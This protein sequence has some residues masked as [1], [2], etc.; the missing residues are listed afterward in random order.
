MR[1]L[2]EIH[3]DLRPALD[4]DDVE[5]MFERADELSE[6]DDHRAQSFAAWVRGTAYRIKR[7]FEKAFVEY[8]KSETI[9]RDNDD[10]RATLRAM[11]G[12]ARTNMMMARFD[13]ALKGFREQIPYAIEHDDR[14]VMAHVMGCIGICEMEL[15]DL[16]GAKEHYTKALEI[17]IELGDQLNEAIVRGNIGNVHA[18]AS[19]YPGA[20]E[21]YLKACRLYEDLKMTDRL[22][23]MYQNIGQIHSSLGNPERGQVYLNK[24][25]ELATKEGNDLQVTRIQGTLAEIE[26]TNGELDSALQRAQQA[27][28]RFV[29]LNDPMNALRTASMVAQIYLDQGQLDKARETLERIDVDSDTALFARFAQLNAKARYLEASGDLDGAK[30]TYMRCLATASEIGQRDEEA[31]IHLALRDLSEKRDDLRAYVEHNRRYSEITEETR[32]SSAAMKLAMVEKDREMAEERQERDRERAILHS[33]LPSH[34]ADRLVRGEDVSGDEHENASV[35]FADIVAFTDHAA[36]MTPA[37]VTKLLAQVFEHFDALCDEHNVTKIK[38]I[39]DS[40]LAVAFEE[41][42]ATIQGAASVAIAIA[43]SSFTWPDGSPLSLR[44]GIDHGPVVSGVIGT[45][46]LQYDVWGDTVNTASRMEGSSEE[47]KV[48]CTEGFAAACHPEVYPECSEGP[49]SNTEPFS[50]TKR[51]SIDI[52]GKGTMTTY[53]LEGA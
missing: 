39:G 41:S 30:E 32:G 22:P 4:R 34:I 35:L 17:H 27:E 8:E 15:G 11:D 38:T 25:I 16:P 9:A 5:T 2:E 23:S 52:K 29:E 10:D 12:A 24:G 31:S 40:Y 18:Q 53:W 33:T 37:E 42:G 47:G 50:V 49:L 21:C 46:R 13:D 14:N 19:D 48:H 1:S 20:L 3:A 44:I 28:R 36:K 6:Y 7:Q 26:R 51:G 43:N 45:Q